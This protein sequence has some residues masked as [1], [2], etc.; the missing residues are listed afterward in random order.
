MLIYQ[1]LMVFSDMSEEDKIGWLNDICSTIL[2]RWFFDSRQD[3]FHY[4]REVITDKDHP[5]NYWLANLDHDTGRVRCHFCDKSYA[6]VGSLMSHEKKVHN[7]GIE[8]PLKKSKGTGGDE[9]HSYIL[10]LFKLF[11]LHKNLDTAVDMGDG[12]RSVRSAKYELPIY[13]RTNKVK[14]CIGSI[15]LTSL[16]SGLLPKEQTERFVANR[17]INLQGGRNNNIALDEFIE[18]LNRDSKIACSGYKTK[19]SI[20]RHSKEYPH[21]TNS[22]RHFDSLC[23][24][25]KSKGFHHLPS[26]KEDVAKVAK[27][28]IEIDALN[29]QNQR[30]LHCK[31]LVTERNPFDKCFHGLSTMV[32][33]HKPSVPFRRLRD[34]HF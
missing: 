29:P 24:V 3:V 23:A 25:R 31:E 34:R 28:L 27:D 13:N 30:T 32:H 15:H 19:E 10:M 22:I 21:L 7:V 20:I 12:E 8:K 18:M 5:E 26:F 1:Y 9:L 2:R 17:F 6:Y 4:L 14:Y 16:S 11:L 33:R